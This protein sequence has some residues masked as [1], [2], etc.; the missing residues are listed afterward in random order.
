MRPRNGPANCNKLVTRDGSLSV[1]R[2]VDTAITLVDHPVLGKP[3]YQLHPCQSAQLL[4]DAALQ[5][6]EALVFWWDFYSS[7]LI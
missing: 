1:D 6:L 5:G 4:D 2:R 3:F 7:V